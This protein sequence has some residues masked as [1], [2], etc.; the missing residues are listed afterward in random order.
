MTCL[1]LSFNFTKSS[2]ALFNC[3]VTLTQSHIIVIS[4]FTM[5]CNRCLRK[6]RYYPKNCSFVKKFPPSFSISVD[7]GNNKTNSF[8]TLMVIGPSDFLST[9]KNPCTIYTSTWRL[10]KLPVLGVTA[11][12]FTYFPFQR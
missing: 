6:I 9:N 3:L 1:H 12:L 8:D 11:K 7:H 2:I 4:N 10:V 5:I